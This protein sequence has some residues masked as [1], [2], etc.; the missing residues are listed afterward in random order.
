MDKI[1]GPTSTSTSRAR[2]V[3]V[4]GKINPLYSSYLLSFSFCPPTPTVPPFPHLRVK[5]S[6][7]PTRGDSSPV[8]SFLSSLPPVLPRYV[9]RS[10]RSVLSPSFTFPGP[11]SRT[12]RTRSWSFL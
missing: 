11:R 3:D 8:H 2:G 7:G 4:D 12:D 5:A 9:S 6:R 1:Q 10:S